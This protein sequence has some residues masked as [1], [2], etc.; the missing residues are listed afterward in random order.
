MAD[1][2]D[3]KSVDDGG[4]PSSRGRARSMGRGPVPGRLAVLTGV[5]L[6]AG[7]IPLPILP[8][9]VLVHVRGA[10]AHE[11]ATRYGLSLS[12]DARAMLAKP[13]S[14]DKVRAVLRKA[15]ELVTRRLLRRLSPFAPLAV[16]ASALEVF[17]LGLL[18]DRYFDRVRASGT[19]RVQESEAQRVRTAIDTAVLRAFYPSTRPQK[20]LLP[21]GVEDLRDEFTRWI[22]TILVGG[23]TLPSYLE[24]RLVAA[25][26]DLV[27]SSP[28]LREG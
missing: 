9:R 6:A 12:A 7:A 24:R 15:V 1:D 19:L 10:I 22:D 8:D 16:G 14:Q 21:E 11:T 26:D 27:A 23:A 28:D 20:L 2:N 5:S 4:S 13:V 18:L 17:A 3:T 25:F